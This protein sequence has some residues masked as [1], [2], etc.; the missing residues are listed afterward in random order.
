MENTYR[1]KF[2]LHIKSLKYVLIGSALSFLVFYFNLL[3]QK[4]I[5]DLKAFAYGA[6]PVYLVLFAPALYLH[7]T[8]YI[9]NFGLEIKIDE[10][11]NRL[12]IIKRGKEYFYSLSNIISVEQH[13]GLHYRD[14][15]DFLGRKMAPWTTY[16][17]LT[18]KLND[19]L[20]F[21]LTCL[22]VDIHNPPFKTT[23]TFFRSF[24][25]LK[26]GK[27]FSDKRA[28]IKQNFENEI[29]NYKL[30]FKNHTDQQLEEKIKKYKTYDKAS[31]EA[32]KQL[33]AKRKI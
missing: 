32:S 24:P 30:T 5:F 16:G 15:I 12:I 25:Y 1:T 18:I 11:N 4:E 31:V 22:M 13:L 8:Y 20:R 26:I 3:N 33:L 23:H 9:E 29:S 21:R 14:R 28:I 17:Y 27:E 2:V 10:K 7:I 19:G 6:L